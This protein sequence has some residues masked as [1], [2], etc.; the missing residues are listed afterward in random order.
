MDF[1]KLI[2]QLLIQSFRLL[3]VTLLPMLILTCHPSG[4]TLKKSFNNCVFNEMK[5]EFIEADSFSFNDNQAENTNHYFL[6]ETHQLIAGNS[7]SEKQNLG[8]NYNTSFKEN[9]GLG[10]FIPPPE[11][12]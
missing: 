11:I 3:S 5:L 6:E 12:I 2:N 9:L 7:S 1:N 4:T 8:F 10:I